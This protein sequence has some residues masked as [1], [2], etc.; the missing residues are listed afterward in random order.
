MD[1]ILKLLRD[2]LNFTPSCRGDIE[3]CLQDA[4][5]PV[6]GVMFRVAK[7]ELNLRADGFSFHK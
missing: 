3:H 6:G 2:Q 1:S 4:S 7:R 5:N